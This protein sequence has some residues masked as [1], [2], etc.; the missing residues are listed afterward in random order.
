MRVLD[1]LVFWSGMNGIE[2]LV[3]R[4]VTSSIE[5][6]KL[7]LWAVLPSTEIIRL[8]CVRFSTRRPPQ[9]DLGPQGR[10]ETAKTN[11]IQRRRMD[12]TLKNTLRSGALENRARQN[13]LQRQPRLTERADEGCAPYLA[14]M[15]ELLLRLSFSSTTTPVP[16]S[17]PHLLNSRS[18]PVRD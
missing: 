13:H 1:P 7:S 15:T 10:P 11:D 18:R 5:M 4:G 2:S 3:T 17:T 6:A 16:N 8:S 14:M 9:D 12:M